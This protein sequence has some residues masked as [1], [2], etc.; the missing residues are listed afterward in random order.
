M[1]AC[2]VAASALSV[3][4]EGTA[5]ASD[6]GP[7][8]EEVVREHD[9]DTSHR[10]YG[11]IRAGVHYP[12]Q[13]AVASGIIVASLPRDFDCTTSCAMRGL[14]VQGALG[15]GGA[16]ASIGYGS[17]VGETG[18]NRAFLRH[19]FVGY[20]VRASYLRTWGSST[21]SPGDDFVGV[22]SAWTVSQFGLTVGVYHRVPGDD[23]GE[24]WK[25]FGGLGWGF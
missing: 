19:V 9:A 16:E 1:V 5:L 25:V 6:P 15:P 4:S 10:V 7:T 11:L 23:P 14:T 20:G 21:L 13:V 2:W 3:A 8:T 24:S 17:L 22:E 18:G 12:M